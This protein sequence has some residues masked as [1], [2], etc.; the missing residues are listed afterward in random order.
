MAGQLYRAD[1][2]VLTI[3][4]RSDGYLAYRVQTRVPDEARCET[5]G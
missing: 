1:H 4:N 3:Q 5:Q 2:M